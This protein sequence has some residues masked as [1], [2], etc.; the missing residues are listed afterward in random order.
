MSEHTPRRGD[1][2]WD[3]NLQGNG[4]PNGKIINITWGEDPE[5]T[6]E[7]FDGQQTWRAYDLNEIE[8]WWYPE[9]FGG[10]YMVPV[11][12]PRRQSVKT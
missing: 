1:K 10:I 9:S 3:Q 7:F 5:V 11:I 12:V 8:D 6:V 2:F 4:Q